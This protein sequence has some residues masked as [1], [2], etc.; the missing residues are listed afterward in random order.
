MIYLKWQLDG[1]CYWQPGINSEKYKLKNVRICTN[2]FGMMEAPTYQFTSAA[3]F[4]L[5]YYIGGSSGLPKGRRFNVGDIIISD[6]PY[7]GQRVIKRVKLCKGL[8]DKMN[9]Y[10][11][12]IN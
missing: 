10:E 11:I 1:T 8:Y 3:Q 5:F 7:I 12:E 9:H 6:D 2:D 4:V